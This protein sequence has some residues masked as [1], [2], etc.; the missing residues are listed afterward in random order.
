MKTS[1]VLDVA[2][3][4]ASALAAAHA[5]G[6][7]HRDIKPENI[8]LRP[9]GYIKVLDFG[10]AKLTELQGGE[11]DPEAVTK[12]LVRT[13][14]GVVMG[15]PQYMSPEQARGQTVDARTDI[16][17]LG[18]VLYEMV[19]GRV[20]FDGSTAG[21][22][23]A[24]I[25]WREP[26]PMAR[27]SRDVPEALEWIVTK[28]LRKERDERYQTAKELLTDLKSLKQSLEF[29]AERERTEA[30]EFIGTETAPGSSEKASVKDTAGSTAQTEETKAALP[31]SSAE[32]L[33]SEI[34]RHQ[35]GALLA[36]AA[37]VIVAAS[38]VFAVY[39]RVS[40]NRLSINSASPFQ[41]LKITRLT[42]TGKASAAALSPDGN[43]VVHVVVEDGGQESLWMRQVVT[44][45]NVQIVP[46]ANVHYYQLAFSNDGN[47]IYF[48]TDG[49]YQMPAL[50]GVPRKLMTD[51]DSGIA[52][53]PDGQQ[54]A[55][56]RGYPAKLEDALMVANADGS[57]ERPL[58]TLRE[59]DFFFIESNVV[60]PAWSP[61][62]K[63][64]ACAA[65]GS[66]SGGRYMTLVEVRLADGAVR[67]IT[68]QRWWRVGSAAWT[69]DGRG[70]VFS[71][72]EQDS[73]PFQLWYAS[74]PGGEVRRVTND[75]N[76]YEG[77]SLTADSAAAVSVQSEQSSNIWV[78]PD[79]D[80]SR[81]KQITSGKSNGT[82]GVAWTPDGRVVFTSSASGSPNIWI[83]DQGGGHQKQLTSGAWADGLPSV[84]PDGRYIVFVSNRTGGD[85]I[86]RIDLDGSNPT[87]LTSGN[88]ERWPHCTPDSK[89]VIYASF[90]NFRLWKVPISGGK[91]AQLTDNTTA[92][93]TI[94]PDG[95]L[96]SCGYYDEH[97]LE[98]KLAIIPS[99][100][101]SPQ[102]VLD[103]PQN[104][105]F[106]RVTYPWTPDG[107]ALSYIGREA[108][109]SN[110][111][112]LPLSGGQPKQMTDFKTDHIFSF[113]WSRDGEQLAL[114]R[115]TETSDVVLIRDF[116]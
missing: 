108:G 17:S 24:T 34:K 103:V 53:S 99:D 52:L 46:P 47:H 30:P 38:L 11:V 75:V 93:P 50:G 83:M 76:N 26:P 4:I 105:T 112:R 66:D 58:A 20:P 57:A 14:P 68:T 33:V 2:A 15:T 55:F 9:D 43:Y 42:N 8:M 18:V 115:G 81:A 106:A 109:V 98:W 44:D 3:Q 37:L 51:I 65:G 104:F 89:W 74:Y 36:L 107:Q 56:I 39:K 113:D 97:T 92:R 63:S 85:H 62:G 102:T 111:W 23:V 116:R 80:V 19:A 73:I 12:A 13:D 21:D 67:R 86:W 40:Q 77:V 100:G 114:A 45:S 95:K 101:G 22:V 96:I 32:Y 41:R 84:S 88:A 31:T 27:Y 78:V 90:G 16:W 70:L 10:L 29:V 87:Q 82:Q 60:R 49:L 28:A 110:V 35:T 94:S 71:A 5:A 72:K 91:P 7:V 25:L 59:P 1:E 54:F 6:I 64:I 48:N 61:D 79:A 69:N